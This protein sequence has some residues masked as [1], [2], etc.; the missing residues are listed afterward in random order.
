MTISEVSC[1]LDEIDFTDKLDNK[2]IERKWYINV[3]CE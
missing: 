2:Q 1:F 3:L